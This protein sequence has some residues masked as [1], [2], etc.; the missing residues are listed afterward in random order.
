MMY[1]IFGSYDFAGIGAKKIKKT[2]HVPVSLKVC[3]SISK[4]KIQIKIRSAVV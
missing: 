4:F 3:R 2:D 1:A